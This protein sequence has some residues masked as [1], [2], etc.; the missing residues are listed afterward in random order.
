VDKNKWYEKG[1]AE[2]HT[3]KT[4]VVALG[5][6]E[7]RPMF[8]VTV[9]PTSFLVHSLHYEDTKEA[10]TLCHLQYHR[11]RCIK[12]MSNVILRSKIN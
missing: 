4:R 11:C 5:P 10:T 8:T 9:T 12:K 7:K 1:Q 6:V 3:R 2:L